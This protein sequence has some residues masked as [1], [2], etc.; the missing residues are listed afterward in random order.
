MISMNKF[1]VGLLVLVVGAAVGWYILGGQKVTLPFPAPRTIPQEVS[2]TAFSEEPSDNTV[3]V[4]QTTVTY[5]DAGFTPKIVTVKKR[6][7]ATFVN[8]SR[9]GM[10]VA[11]DVHPTHQLLPGLDQG[12]SVGR[13]GTYEY[14]FIKVGTWKYHNHVAPQDSGKV[15]VIE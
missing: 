5:T 13:G 2:P 11:S 7:T 3:T 4:G 12:K 1:L 14:T 15:V 9:A 8:Q 10:W 6:T